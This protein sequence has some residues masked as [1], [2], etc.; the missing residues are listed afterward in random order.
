MSII[1][2]III[3]PS[4]FEKRELLYVLRKARDDVFFVAL[5]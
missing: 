3:S 4:F 1:I 2:I 5:N